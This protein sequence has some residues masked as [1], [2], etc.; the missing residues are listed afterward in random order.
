MEKK[1]LKLTN[2]VYSILAFFPE[3]DPLKNRTKEK[4]LGI[5]ENL[6]LFFSRQISIDS[7]K[8]SP[9][10]KPNI[11]TKISED[12]A[13]LLDYLKIG[14][15]QGWISDVNYLIISNEYE[16][17]R[18]E[19]ELS[20]SLSQKMPEL[21]KIAKER[22]QKDENQKIPKI[23]A[24]QNKIVDFLKE[25]G[26]AQVMDLKAVLPDVTK[27]TIRR[28]LDELLAAGKVTRLGEFNQIFYKII[29]NQ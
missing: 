20:A 26:K 27:R 7:L 9:Q 16:K 19:I 11:Q 21:P 23:S 15:F 10:D 2:T 17:I 28:D 6:I 22:A 18:K 1:I 25:K 14:K 3:A 5:M 4:V 24:R 8:Y 13:M 29:E 12:I